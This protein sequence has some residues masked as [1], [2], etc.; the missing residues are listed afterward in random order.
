VMQRVST[1]TQSHMLLIRDFGSISLSQA[2]T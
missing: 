1:T 2:R